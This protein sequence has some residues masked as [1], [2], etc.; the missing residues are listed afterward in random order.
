[1]SHIEVRV[2]DNHGRHSGLVPLVNP[3]TLIRFD[4]PTP[5]S[6]VTRSAE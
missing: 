6:A 4:T 5:D 1:M 3:Q 2:D